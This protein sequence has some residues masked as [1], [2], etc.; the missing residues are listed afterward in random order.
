MAAAGAVS[1]P[2]KVVS[3]AG[4]AVVPDEEGAAAHA[5]GLRFDQAEHSLHR[6]KR[7]RRVAA[8][9]QHFKPCLGG[10]RIGRDDHLTFGPDGR[11]RFDCGLGLRR[12]RIR[13]LLRRGRPGKQQHQGERPP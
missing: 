8:G 9:A 10:Q 4:L 3:F 11:L 2:S 1:R 12:D 13:R 5:G 7:I 6:H